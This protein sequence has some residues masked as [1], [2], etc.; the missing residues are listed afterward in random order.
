MTCHAYQE[1]GKSGTC[2]PSC[3]EEGRET[4]DDQ[5]GKREVQVSEGGKDPVAKGGAT[6]EGVANWEETSASLHALGRVSAPPTSFD[7]VSGG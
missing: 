6:Q 5:E 2:C 7:R 3:W 1:E 4:C